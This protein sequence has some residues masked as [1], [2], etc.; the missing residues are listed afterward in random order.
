MYSLHLTHPKWT[1]T[2]SSGQPCYSARGAVGG[3]GALLKDTSV[4]VL[5]EDTPPTN[6][7]C[8]T[9]DSNSQP[10]AYESDSL[11]IRPR[12][13]VNVFMSS[14]R[15]QTLKII[16]SAVYVNKTARLLHHTETQQK[17][18]QDSYLNRLL[19][20]NIYRYKSI[21]RFDLS[22]MTYFWL[23]HPNFDKFRDIPR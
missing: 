21:L 9:W 17:N 3:F 20:L 2:R 1:H 19:R 23:I 22:V 7:P 13:P 4:V 8:R 18:M 12:L 6:N 16:A 5:K 11:S 14:L 10:S 15:R